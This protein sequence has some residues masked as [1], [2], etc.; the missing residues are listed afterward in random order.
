[1]DLKLTAK[2][3]P[4]ILFHGT[5][6]R[7]LE[8]ITATGLQKRARQHVHLSPDEATALKVGQRHG[9]PVILRVR[10]KAMHD[11]GHPFYL[12]DNGV[13]LVD[14]VPP[15]FLLSGSD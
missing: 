11:V 12:S 7:N 8:S 9:K 3:P 14:A 2:E 6:A 1:V 5:A 10:A 4:E 15:E 13:W